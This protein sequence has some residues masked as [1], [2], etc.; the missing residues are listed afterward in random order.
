M[1]IVKQSTCS[2]TRSI[3]LCNKKEACTGRYRSRAKQDD[4][5]YVA[6]S[7][8]AQS[9]LG[10]TPTRISTSLQL[11]KLSDLP[12]FNIAVDDVLSNQ[13]LMDGTIIAVAL[14]FLFSFL[15]GRSPSSSNVK[16]WPEDRKEN[17]Y[18]LMNNFSDE[19]SMIKTSD[20]Q[21]ESDT[22]IECNGDINAEKVSMVFDGDEWRDI[23]KPANYLLYTS[24]L[25]NKEQ[26]LKDMQKSRSPTNAAFRK[27]SRL[28][29]F[30]LLALFVPIFSLEFFF[31]LSRQFLC[32]DFVTE[33]SDSM[34]LTDSDRALSSLNGLSPWAQEL[35][36]PHL[37]RY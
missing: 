22:N 7:L 13:D 31:A 30:A 16:L 18:K 28:V 24:K 3:Q 36:S 8:V 6:S 26:R 4:A 19:K 33:V 10:F 25:R 15:Q 5:F 37:D 34:W 9:S 21:N 35:C 27:E 11:S 17:D 20:K 23:S 1:F 14:A 32:G 29:F 12:S 2:T